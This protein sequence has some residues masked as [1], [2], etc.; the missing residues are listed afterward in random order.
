MKLSWDSLGKTPLG[1][2]YTYKVVARRDSGGR[3]QTIKSSTSNT[4]SGWFDIEDTARRYTVEVHT[5][6]GPN[7]STGYRGWGVQA[8]TINSASC[9]GGEKYKANP[10]SENVQTASVSASSKSASFASNDLAADEPIDETVD[11]TTD[12]GTDD[13]VD[14][15]GDAGEGSSSSGGGSPIMSMSA[16]GDLAMQ[17]SSSQVVITDVAGN[18]VSTIAVGEDAVVLWAADSDVLWI[19][20]SGELFV[21]QSSGGWN[22]SEVDPESA[23]VPEYIAALV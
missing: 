10:S 8:H 15:G 21:A 7:T 23:E 20:D 4:N 12:T 2:D 16:S 13:A 1:E 17:V 3:T 18:G 19:V 5:I 9:K 14:A 6:N 22:K 11:D